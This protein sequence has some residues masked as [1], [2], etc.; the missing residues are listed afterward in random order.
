MKT[1]HDVLS[2]NEKRGNLHPKRSKGGRNLLGKVVDDTREKESDDDAL[3]VEPSRKMKKTGSAPVMRA[4]N[5]TKNAPKCSARSVVEKQQE[6]IKE[7]VMSFGV[8]E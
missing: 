7:K 5:S 4:M 6:G 8:V 1:V 2:S 3:F